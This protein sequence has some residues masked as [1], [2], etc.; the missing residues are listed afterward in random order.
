[1]TSTPALKHR[2]E[3]FLAANDYIGVAGIEFITDADG[4]VYAYDVNTNTNYNPEAEQTAGKSGMG[5]IAQY[6]GRAADRRPQRVG[7]RAAFRRRRLSA[8]SAWLDAVSVRQPTH[9][10]RGTIQTDASNTSASRAQ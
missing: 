6:L 10:A 4:A 1:M 3:A 9:S 8:A 2:Y 5:A 7:A